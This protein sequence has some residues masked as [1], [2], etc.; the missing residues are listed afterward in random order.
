MSTRRPIPV[1]LVVAA[2]LACT[3]STTP[4]SALTAEQFEYRDPA[5]RF[6]FSY[7]RSFGTTSIGTDDGFGNRVAAVRFS[8][9]SRE[10]I[11]GEA[12]LGQG[13]PSLDIQAAGGLY[14]DILTGA[15]PVTLQNVIEAV[16]PP[17]TRDSLCGQIG[18]EQHVDTSAPAFASLTPSQREGISM[19]D[20][21]GNVA[22]QVFRCIVSGDTVVFDKDAAVA[23]A[24][25]PRRR[26][27]GAVRFLEGRYSTFQLIRGNGSVNESVFDDMR[28]VV[29][30]W[31]GQ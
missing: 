13:R 26:V 20:R 8:V 7:P 6:A 5:S 10:A 12:V 25:A 14:D 11:G 17:L 22:P 19:L 27:Y 28:S 30:S 31:R 29:T 18:R 21:M 24:G 4:P 2:T 16:L 3:A 23:V 15:L 9:F 1:A